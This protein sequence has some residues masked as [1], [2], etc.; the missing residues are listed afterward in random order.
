MREIYF[1]AS[2]F[3]KTEDFL[4]ECGEYYH[5]FNLLFQAE[6]DTK[7]DGVWWI[8]LKEEPDKVVKFTNGKGSSDEEEEQDSLEEQRDQLEKARLEAQRDQLEKARL[9]AQRDQLEK[10]RLEAQRDQL[11]KDMDATPTT[12][13]S[14]FDKSPRKTLSP[15][16]S[17]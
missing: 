12:S 1:K 13:W 2:V 16:N 6:Q 14:M 10:A 4:Q 17:P 5:Q 9:E 3:L 15:K 8:I 7:I 11:E